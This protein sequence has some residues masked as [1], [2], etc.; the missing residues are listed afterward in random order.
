MPPHHNT[1]QKKSVRGIS[2]NIDHCSTSLCRTSGVAPDLAAS[3]N[4][5]GMEDRSHCGNLV[6]SWILLQTTVESIRVIKEYYKLIE[7]L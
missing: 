4:V 2:K 7:E 6:L 3:A 1:L 5:A